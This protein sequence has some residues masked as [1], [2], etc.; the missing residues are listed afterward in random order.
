MYSLSLFPLW[1][2][3]TKNAWQSFLIVI[4]NGYK[5]RWIAQVTLGNVNKNTIFIG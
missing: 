1:D 3:V 2:E 5:Y 4:Q